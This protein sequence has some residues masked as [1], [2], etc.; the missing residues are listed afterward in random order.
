MKN[1]ISILNIKKPAFTMIEVLFVIVV[2]GILAS[3]ALPRLDRDIRQEAADNVL[4]AI[5]YTQHMAVI[6]DKTDPFDP[7]WQKGFWQIQFS[8]TKTTG[9]LFYVIGSDIDHTGGS[10]AYPEKIETAMDPT[11]GKYFFHISTEPELLSDESPNLLL[12]K[13]F[14][15]TDVTP[16]D[17]C[18]TQQL[19]FDQWGRP[20]TNVGNASNDYS[21]YMTEDC[22]LKFT[23]ENDSIAVPFTIIIT[24]ETGYAYIEGQP[25]S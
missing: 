7:N 24:K 17:G 11:N 13:S 10:T 19:A 4:S 6:D 3:L 12:G 5:R 18:T 21:T 23:F 2:L 25:D 22:R 15:V 14:A 16:K 20:H 1:F 8:T 9:H